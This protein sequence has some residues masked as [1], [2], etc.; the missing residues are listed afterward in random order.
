MERDIRP[1]LIFELSVYHKKDAHDADNNRRSSS[2]ELT[3]GI[4]E[5]NSSKK[6]LAM[7]PMDFFESRD[8][9][10]EKQYISW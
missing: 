1:S 6:Y 8:S 4:Y 2:L 9:F 5:Y 7:I 3:C 10:K